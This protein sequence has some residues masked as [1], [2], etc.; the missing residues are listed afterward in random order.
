MPKTS[1]L[2]RRQWFKSSAAALAGLAI[3]PRLPAASEPAAKPTGP[4]RLALNE[5]P[6]G[7]SAAAV[8][9]MRER[10][11]DVCRYP[12]ADGRDLVAL[13][14]DKEGVKPDQIVLGAGSGEILEAC[15]QL[16]GGP[17]G[18]VV[19]AKPTYGQLTAAMARCGSTLLEVPLNERKEHD[20]AAMAAAVTAKTQCVYVCNPNNPTGTVV[21]AGQLWDFARA[22]AATAPVV[23]DEAY[24]EC[25]DDFAGRTLAGLVAEGH[26]VIVLR[27][28]SKIHALAGQRIGY[29]IASPEMAA[30]LGPYVIGGPN[31]LALVG[32]RANLEDVAYTD[33]TRR[34]IKAGRDALIA[35]LNELGC[36][37][38]VPHG[39]FVF[40]HSGVPIADF[41]PRML[42]EGVHV[43][44]PFPPFLDWC[45]I[46]IGTPE[47]MAA[48]HAALRVV[49]G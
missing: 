33:R 21:D 13:L 9:A 25:S 45:R 5:N 8:A 23:V 49:L 41:R 6:F 4:V 47:E 27:T 39:N 26:D 35:V 32:A 36:D 24:L 30:K 28:F 10:A 29:G 18:E 42:A 34:E 2:N 40:F 15:G 11:A 44:R 17:G 38:A 37:Y 31:L 14:A 12:M 7:P 19:C 3:A 48:A 22:A 16:L 1:P 43:G 20:L 46:S